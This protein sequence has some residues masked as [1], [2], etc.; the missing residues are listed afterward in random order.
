[1][2]RQYLL[3]EQLKIIKRELG[4]QKDDKDAI[5]EKFRE[6]V[7]ELVM[8]DSVKQVVEEE[9]NKLSFLDNHSAEFR[10]L[11]TYPFV[12][13]CFMYSYAL[14]QLN[15]K[16]FLSSLSAYLSMSDAN[17]RCRVMSCDV[18]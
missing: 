13:V 8:P 6:R 11:F 5:S 14:R 15:P 10:Y 18:M 4:L 17:T 7:V 12:V 16:V 2:Q 9:L 3:Q 1:M